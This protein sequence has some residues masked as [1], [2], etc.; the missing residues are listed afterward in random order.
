MNILNFYIANS[1]KK[2]PVPHLRGQK[3]RGGGPVGPGERL[4]GE[5]LRKKRGGAQVGLLPLGKH[6]LVGWENLWLTIGKPRIIGKTQDFQWLTM[7][8]DVDT[9]GG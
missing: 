2:H 6:G 8:K 1:I 5:A 9:Y 4:T 3:L 7:V